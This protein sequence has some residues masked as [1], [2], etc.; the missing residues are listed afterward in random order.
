MY[1][2]LSLL[3]RASTVTLSV[4][5]VAMTAIM[6]TLVVTRY[7]FA[8]S[9]PWSEEATRFLMVW[10]VMLGGAILVLFDDHITLYILVEKLG[11]RM[12]LLQAIAV[13]LVI[14]GVSAVTA[15]TGYEFAFSMAGVIAPG[16]GVSMAVPTIAVPIS[17]T[18]ITLFAL[19]LIL[20]DLA[21]HFGR[22]GPR[23]PRQSDHMDG[24]FRPAEDPE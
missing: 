20:R 1:R 7:V 12:R 3:C 14:A 19:L 13:R 4:C 15:W 17:M 16:S 21:A 11:P 2:A 22:T 9:A 5:I 23:M 8:F 24:S 10:M 18:L 6:V